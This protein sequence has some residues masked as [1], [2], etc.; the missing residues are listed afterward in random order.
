MCMWAQKKKE[1]HFWQCIVYKDL[2]GVWAPE[3]SENM[4]TTFNKYPVDETHINLYIGVGYIWK[5]W[6]VVLHTKTTISLLIPAASWR[7]VK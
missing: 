1:M 6:Q 2:R 7:K 5:K 4:G 3:D